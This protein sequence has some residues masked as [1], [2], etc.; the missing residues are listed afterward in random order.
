MP[1]QT[2]GLLMCRKEKEELEFFLVHPGGPFYVKKNEGAWS[3]P[4]GLPE[5]NEE[6]QLT[7]EREFFEET[8]ITPVPP[9]QSLGNAKMKSG[10]VIH[11]WT[12]LGTWNPEDGIVSNHIEIEWPPRTGKKIS[13]PETDR[14]EWMDFQKAK[15][16]INS[17][18][19]VFL[20]R[21]QE[22]YGLKQKH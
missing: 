2:A 3:I 19:L 4:K 18:Q 12:F 9:Y 20:E 5:G 14:G 11:A 22:H 6:L 16:M 13:I 17:S 10:K 7:A 15:V 1:P 8:G 21:A